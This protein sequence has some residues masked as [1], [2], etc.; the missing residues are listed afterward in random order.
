MRDIRMVDLKGQY[1]KIKSEID[2]SI[3]EVLDSTAFINGSPVHEFCEDLSSYTGSKHVIP[4][5]NGT[6]ALQVSLM[7][8]DLQPGDEVITVPFTFVATA[9]VISLLRLKPVFVDV[10]ANYFTIDTN[11]LEDAITDKT[12]CIIPVHLYGQSAFMEPLME[13]AEKHGLPVIE[14]NAQAIG[15]DYF[16]ADESSR[17][18][19]SIGTIGCTSFFPSKNLGAFGDAGAIMTDD[20]KL[21]EK[22]RIITNH[23]SKEKYYNDWIGVNSRLDTLQA[24]ILKVKLKHLDEYIAARRKAA[25]HYD[26]ALHHSSA[27]IP[28]RAPYSNHVFHQYT[29]VLE[30]N[31]DQANKE[32]EKLG[33]PSMIYYPV[34]MHLQKAYLDAGYKKGDFPVTEMLSEKVLSL[35][36]HTELDQEQLEYISESFLNVVE[37]TLV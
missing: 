34:P 20:D 37:K 31:R 4:C 16:Y 24:A 11:Q 15:S 36:M 22:L 6:D 8:L 1:L 7:A 33:V 3:M 21:A 14:D 35:P 12:K 30:N 19:G 23:G 5:A 17:K 28:E 2:A 32:L 27:R 9:E 13:I 10:D 29:L 26:K 25:D 18:S